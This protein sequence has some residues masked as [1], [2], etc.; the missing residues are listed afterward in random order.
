MHP[1]EQLRESE[2]H[3]GERTIHVVEAGHPNDPSVVFLHGWP[4]TWRAWRAVLGLAARQAH[5]VAVDL[6]GVGRSRGTATDGTKSQ[7]ADVLHELV[8]HLRL[9]DVTLVGHDIGGMVAFAYLRR[10]RDLG[11][12][13]VMDTVLPGLDPWEAVRTSPYIWHFG[14]HAVPALPEHLV[15]GRERAY[16]DY[17]YDVLAADADKI[18]DEARDAYAEA[19]ATDRALTAGF[20]WYRAFDH[21]SRDNQAGPA[22][23]PA[24]LLYL[25]GEHEGGDM[26]TYV[27]GLRGCGLT[28]VSHGVVPGA[29]HFAPEEAPEAT[30]RLIADFVAATN[31]SDGGSR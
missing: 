14:L 21:D 2:Q 29:G 3:I 18:T 30:W 11:R 20:D 16:F 25:R 19:Y 27:A 17:F 13:V 28:Q 10:H 24:P 7:I 5:A 12:A 1:A 6:P 26:A 9:R 15:R 8:E 31:G 23:G 22:V 4:Q